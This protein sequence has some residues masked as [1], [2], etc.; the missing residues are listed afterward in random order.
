MLTVDMMRAPRA[1][2]PTAV[3]FMLSATAREALRRGKDKTGHDMST[4]VD[5]LIQREFGGLLPKAVSTDEPE[6]FPRE[7]ETPQ[8]NQTDNYG[9]TSRD[10]DFEF[11]S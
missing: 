5:W 4:L 3:K 9:R 1:D 6:L 7:P 10:P 8:R 2:N 11:D